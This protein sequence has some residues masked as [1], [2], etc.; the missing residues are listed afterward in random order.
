[1]LLQ[2]D[3]VMRFCH[4][5]FSRTASVYEILKLETRRS[6]FMR[7]ISAI[8]AIPVAHM[9]L[10]DDINLLRNTPGEWNRHISYGTYLIIRFYRERSETS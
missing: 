5:N 10:L 9:N 2:T 7:C 4:R 1:M 3:D 6:E 8:F